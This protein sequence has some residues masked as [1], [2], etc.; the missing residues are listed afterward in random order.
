M[1]KNSVDTGSL[2]VFADN[3]GN[4]VCND[5]DIQDVSVSG[6]SATFSINSNDRLSPDTN[7]I[8]SISSSI[9][10]NNGNFLDCFDSNAVDSNCEW[11]FST[12]SGSPVITISPSSGPVL[13]SVD[14]TGT[15]FTPLS[16]VTI[17]FDGDFVATATS[18]SAG[19]FIAN[20]DV[21][22]LSS[23]GDHT[24]KASQGS[25]SASKTFTVT[26]LLLPTIILNPTSGPVGASVNITGAGF[27]PSSNV[28]ITFNDTDITTVTTNN[29]GLFFAN[30]TVPPSSIGPVHEIEKND[31]TFASHSCL[32]TLF[33]CSCRR[34]GRRRNPLIH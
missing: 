7:Y 2:S 31:S 24:V 28:D 11:N 12:A 18:T 9:E 4:F 33:L 20:F 15:G 10:D 27:D 29:I 6:K 19:S 16:V 30:F 1:D 32:R 8:A 13:T 25:N 3:C 26:S 17:T 23:I 14:V 34:R 5:P 21:P 22:V